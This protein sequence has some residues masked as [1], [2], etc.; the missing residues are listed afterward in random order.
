ML[1]AK[2]EAVSLALCELSRA[3][4]RGGLWRVRGPPQAHAHMAAD[5]PLFRRRGGAPGGRLRVSAALSLS[6]RS[7]FS[8]FSGASRSCA[9]PRPAT[10]AYLA[11]GMP[12]FKSWSVCAFG[13]REAACVTAA[14]LLG[15]HAPRWLR[16]QP[17]PTRRGARQLQ[18]RIGRD[19]L[20]RPPNGRARDPKRGRLEGG[21]RRGDGTMHAPSGG[22]RPKTSLSL[23]HS[24]YDTA[25][26][27]KGVLPRPSPVSHRL[28]N[29][30][31]RIGCRT[32]LHSSSDT[33]L[34]S[35]WQIGQDEP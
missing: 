25:P 5:H 20:A 9:R 4:G 13:R 7:R 31:N 21:D 30:C 34:F 32:Y 29:G 24:A 17:L 28:P 35:N 18:R 14:A 16:E 12:R 27:R 26:Q 10:S 22:G 2:P 23:R 11:P 8:M 3:H 15:G 33:K 1:K 19:G 6:T